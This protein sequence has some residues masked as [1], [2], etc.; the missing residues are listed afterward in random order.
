MAKR[1][2]KRNGEFSFDFSSL[3]FGQHTEQQEEREI[4]KISTEPA[5]FENAEEMADRLDYD[6]D[7]FAFLSG[8]FV[9]G[10]F[11]EALIF[12]QKLEPSE[13]YVTTLGMGKDNIDSLVNLVEYL[14]CDKLNLLVSHYFASTERHKLMPYMREQFTGLPIDVAVLRSHTKIALIFSEKGNVLISGS[15]NLSSSYNL[16]QIVIMHDENAINFVKAY[17]DD[18]MARFMVFRGLDGTVEPGKNE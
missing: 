18:I 5:C 6:K 15:A 11:L 16:E 8:N 7:Y 1:R 2:K 12:R 4:P 10:D 3:S 14:G 9:F 13:M 17:L